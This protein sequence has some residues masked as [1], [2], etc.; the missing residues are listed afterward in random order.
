MK[1]L[2]KDIDLECECD[3]SS[4]SM[5]Q[6]CSSSSKLQ[7]PTPA[8]AS[9]QSPLKSQ[10]QVLCSRCKCSNNWT[11]VMAN[12]ATLNRT[13]SLCLAEGKG[14][15][16]SMLP[17]SISLPLSLTP[18]AI[19]LSC[20]LWRTI[21]LYTC[22]SSSKTSCSSKLKS[23]ASN[24]LNHLHQT[25][26]NSLCQLKLLCCPHSNDLF[27]NDQSVSVLFQH[28]LF[29]PVNVSFISLQKKLNTE[30]WCKRW[31]TWLVLS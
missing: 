10:L 7:L 11:Q 3:C 5:S 27:L 19:Q 29:V 9:K 13:N 15:S 8:V 20:L 25:L 31:Q 24:N 14:L 21:S 22:S 1:K 18:K 6:L 28:C 12:Q 16:I 26:L 2:S 4:H 23:W 30:L 17:W